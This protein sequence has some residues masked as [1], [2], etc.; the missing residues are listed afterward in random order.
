MHARCRR[1][2]G[3][4]VDGSDL[5][6]DASTLGVQHVGQVTT[7]GDLP[8]AVAA[9]W[10]VIESLPEDIELKRRVFAELDRVAS[11]GSAS[12]DE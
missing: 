12:D 9:A 1:G 2:L 8:E 6:A 7:T 10:L 4:G 5:L 11:P 3:G